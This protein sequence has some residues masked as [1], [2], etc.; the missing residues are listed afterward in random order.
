MDYLDD[1]IAALST[2]V[3]QGGIGIV[4]ISGPASLRI[5]GGMFRPRG[6]G[7]GLA[8]ARTFTLHYGEITDPLTSEVLD[9]VIVSVMRAPH[10]YTREDVVEINCHGGMAAVR[11]TLEAVVGQGARLAAP[12]EF[13]RRAFL[14]GRIS[15]PQAEAVMDLISARTD[16]SRRVAVAQLRGRLSERLEALRHALIEIAAFAEAHMDFPEEE[17]ELQT[18]QEMTSRLGVIAGDILKLSGTFD[19]ARF[20]R[21]GLSAAIVGRPNVGKSSLLNALLQRDRAIVTELPGTTRDTIEEC[22][23]I[24]GLPLRIIDTAGIRKAG[25]I[26]EKEGIRRS[27]D[28]IETAD[29]VLAVFDGSAAA[30]QDDHELL[31]MIKGKKAILVLNKSDLPSR[32]SPD[33]LQQ[34]AQ[35]WLKVSTLT[36]AG[37]GE[38]KTEIFNAHCEHWHEDREGVVVTNLRQ[39]MS[40]DRAAAAL[41]NALAVLSEKRPLE[42]F[43]IELREALDSIGELTGAVTNEMIL[44]RIFSEF[45]IGK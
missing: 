36:G 7:K 39:K 8:S 31:R 41:T 1:T 42:I 12:G 4:R 15:L 24:N 27:L 38:L 37:L 44:D 23:N 43:S 2:P 29:C 35:R 18:E 26:I 25:E 45:C 34:G 9:E 5:A 28:A 20:F 30:Q 40:L 16:E 10:S 17:I 21:E 33:D 22:L 11:R 32:L 6:T 13:T 3:G 14:N 19:E